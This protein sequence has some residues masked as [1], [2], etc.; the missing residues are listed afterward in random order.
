ML[1]LSRT[2][3]GSNLQSNNEMNLLEWTEFYLKV[4]LVL[5]QGSGEGNVSDWMNQCLPVVAVLC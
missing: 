1:Y 4:N 2:F 5:T 3:T